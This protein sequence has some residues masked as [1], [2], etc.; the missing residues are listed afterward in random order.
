MGE[1][2]YCYRGSGVA[3]RR[4][5]CLLPYPGGAWWRGARVDEHAV[6]GQA[7]A[8]VP[9]QRLLGTIECERSALETILGQFLVLRTKAVLI[10]WI[11]KDNEQLWC[12]TYFDV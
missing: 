7:G 9:Q 5:L 6:N 11:G 8:V 4:I 12:S 3:I 10:P 1:W 2:T